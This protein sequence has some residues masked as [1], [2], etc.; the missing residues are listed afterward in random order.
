MS[1]PLT[2]DGFIEHF[3]KA[4]G[5]KCEPATR[6]HD[7]LTAFAQDRVGSTRNIT[8]YHVIFCIAHGIKPFCAA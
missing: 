1:E 5:W 6:I 7:D 2:V 3:R 8:E 4:S